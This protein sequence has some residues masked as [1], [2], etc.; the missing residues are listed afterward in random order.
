MARIRKFPL[1]GEYPRA[2]AV[3]VQISEDPSPVSV[4]SFFN[5]V[6][7]ELLLSRIYP[8]D[9]VM[10][11]YSFKGMACFS[12]ARRFGGHYVSFFQGRNVST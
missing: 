4:Q 3:E 8:A 5:N 9:F 1:S 11:T 2:L 7:P 10:P 6:Q 12:G